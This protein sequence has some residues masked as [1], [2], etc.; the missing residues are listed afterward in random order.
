MYGTKIAVVALIFILGLA[1]FPFAALIAERRARAAYTKTP[2]R[3]GRSGAVIAG[4]LLKKESLDRIRVTD[5][6]APLA[7]TYDAHAGKI[8]L[9]EETARL[10]GA[11][12]AATAAFLVA[13]VVIHA[14]DAAAASRAHRRAS[15][16][17][18][19]ANILPPLIVAAVL[20]PGAG[21]GLGIV[22]AVMLSLIFIYTVLELP[23]EWRAR[24]IAMELIRKH[25][26]SEEKSELVAIHKCISARASARIAAP[27][28]HCFWIRPLL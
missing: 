9:A 23:T 12:A 2:L 16:V 11:F 15:Y 14:E 1:T 22:A 5:E 7:E 6:A 3:R 25:A 27:L 18:V 17:A 13:K 8:V 20:I 21:R 28:K 24:R 4:L 26:V 10:A 19:I